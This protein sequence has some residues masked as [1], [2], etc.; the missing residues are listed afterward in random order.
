[1]PTLHR[2]CCVVFLLGAIRSPLAAA[3]EPPAFTVEVETVLKHDDGK[4]LWYHPR[5]AAI[6]G[7]GK[8]GKPA[9]VMTLQKHLRASDH[10]S[11]LSVMR[12]DDLGATWT[13]PDPRPELDWV[14]ESDRV[15]VA[16]ADVTPAW[17][18]KT[19]RFLTVGAQVR[20]SKAGEQLEDRPRSNQT[21]YAVLDPKTG[22]WLPWKP[23]DMPADARF[24]FARSAC[25]QFVIEPDGTVLLPFYHGRNQNEPWDVTVV[26]CSFDGKEL[27]Y[28]RHGSELVLRVQRGLAEPSLVFFGGKYYLTIRNDEKGY[29]TVS[30]D[31]L[32]WEPMRPWT[33][34]DGAELGSY[35]TQQHWLAHS[36]GLYLV[37]T[38]RGAKN[39]HI[40]RHRATLFIAQVDPPTLRV[41]RKTERV[42]IPERGAELGNFGAAPV[43]ANESWVTVAEGVWDQEAR[44]R[45]AEGAVFVA[46][47]IWSKP[48]RLV[49]EQ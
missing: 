11:G 8:G 30:R 12:T 14:A 39:D 23:L 20:Y 21:A 24:N 15:D 9:V 34:D 33:F 3:D 44:R 31:G 38:R 40:P 25:A 2:A 48:N 47:V 10:Y 22:K 27:K 26:R 37:Y 1:M 42:L 17:H 36:D 46:R 35:N 43:S 5:V 49:G 18:A 28:L 4:F 7:G 45:G 16:V 19:G 6:P 29:V 32:T 13:R 41:L